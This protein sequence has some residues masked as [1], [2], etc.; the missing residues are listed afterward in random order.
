MSDTWERIKFGNARVKKRARS[1]KHTEEVAVA[2]KL[3]GKMMEVE[4]Y[5]PEHVVL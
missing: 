2:N 1:V 5:R 4:V 3:S